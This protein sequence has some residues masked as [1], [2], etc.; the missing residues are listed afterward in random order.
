MAHGSRIGSAVMFVQ[1]L[2]RSVRFYQ[3]VLGLAV[4]D[5]SPTCWSARRERS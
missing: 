1:D 2:G 5:Q 4:T 3:E